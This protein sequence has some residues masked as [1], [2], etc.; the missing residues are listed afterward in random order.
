M[1]ITTFA[2]A[3]AI[4]FLMGGAA[5]AD[6]ATTPAA[7]AAGKPAPAPAKPSSAKSAECSKQADAKQL[8]GAARWKFRAECLKAK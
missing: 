6:T 1:R 4:A 3:A 8:H 2:T 5:F 7:P